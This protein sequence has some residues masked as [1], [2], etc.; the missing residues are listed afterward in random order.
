MDQIKFSWTDWLPWRAW[1][2][3]G[4]VEAADEVPD[5]LPP[6]TAILV[7]THDNPKWLAFDCPCGESHR[8]VVALDP[9]IRPHWKVKSVQRLT[10]MPSVDALRN[11][12]RCH[13]VISNGRI[14]WV[15][16]RERKQ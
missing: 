15:K 7:G 8:I 16:D 3:V 9:K 14:H 1:R 13:Y 10:L 4:T 12:K 11:Q 2:I 5:R 6:K